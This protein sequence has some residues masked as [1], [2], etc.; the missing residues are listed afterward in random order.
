MESI[1]IENFCNNQ[2]IDQLKLLSKKTQIY[3]FKLYKK[4]IC[5]INIVDL[6]YENILNDLEPS[7]KEILLNQYSNLNKGS[8]EDIL[9]DQKGLYHFSICLEEN[10]SICNYV[11]RTFTY[12]NIIK[13]KVYEIEAILNGYKPSTT[14]LL[15]NK[16][17][18]K[19]EKKSN[20][21]ILPRDIIS[22]ILGIT[23]NQKI[24]DMEKE[25]K[26]GQV[27]YK[28]LTDRRNKIR[29]RITYL[30]KKIKSDKTKLYLA[31][32]SK[33]Q[34]EYYKKL[35]FTI[36]DYV[37]RLYYNLDT[38]HWIQFELPNRGPGSVNYGDIDKIKNRYII[39]SEDLSFNLK[40]F[41]KAFKLK[42]KSSESYKKLKEYFQH[43]FQL[44]VDY[45]DIFSIVDDIASEK[46]YKIYEL[47][48]LD[49]ETT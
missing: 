26:I 37:S 7:T 41:L 39:N 28:N 22:K 33:K 29:D 34:L 19:W 2:N 27:E 1:L 23:A 45:Y 21:P 17:V 15:Y 35:K 42:D 30:T 13:W 4:F 31:R 25:L 24:D 32:L 38:G 46:G 49:E 5:N 16:F 8:E 18:D 47:D 43:L 11:D 40:A 9:I 6:L 14:N 44:V 3:M 48:E 20:L 10:Y 12:D 36:H